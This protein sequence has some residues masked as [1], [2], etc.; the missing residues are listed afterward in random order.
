MGHLLPYDLLR[1]TR[2]KP[3]LQIIPLSP[4]TIVPMKRKLRGERK[5][6]L[7][8]CSI[9]KHRLILSFLFQ[10][11][12]AM[13]FPSG[14]GTPCRKL[15]GRT[16]LRAKSDMMQRKRSWNQRSVEWEASIG[17][18]KSSTHQSRNIR[19][20]ATQG[21]RWWMPQ[22]TDLTK[23]M[24]ASPSHLPTLTTDG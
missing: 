24:S 3:D 12:C 11:G 21:D 15:L 14:R 17:P 22:A 2:A 8:E 10:K 5:W 13:L 1:S 19:I 7:W 20:S 4:S 23:K 16:L 18:L 9:E 6:H